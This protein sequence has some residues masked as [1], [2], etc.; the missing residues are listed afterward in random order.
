MV[1]S[2]TLPLTPICNSIS[3]I[4]FMARNMVSMQSIHTILIKAL[5]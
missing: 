4:T 5:H 3:C 1:K 2:L